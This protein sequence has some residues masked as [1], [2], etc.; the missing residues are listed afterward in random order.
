MF[1]VSFSNAWSAATQSAK[2]AVSKIVDES[3]EKIDNIASEIK[4]KAIEIGKKA[5]QKVEEGVQYTKEKANDAKEYTKE[6]AIEAKEYVKQKA[7]ETKEVA[8]K[9]AKQAKK[10]FDKAADLFP[11][12]ASF[13][14]AP[15]PLTALILLNKLTDKN[16]NADWDGKYLPDCKVCPDGSTCIATKGSSEP[17]NKGKMPVSGCCRNPIP[18]VYFVNG[19]MNDPKKNCETAKELAIATCSEV[20]SVYNRTEGIVKDVGECLGNI[21]QVYQ[22]GDNAPTDTMSKLMEDAIMK[23]PPKE[24]TICAHSQGGLITRSSL[25]RVKTKLSLKYPP[26][27]VKERMSKINIKSFGTAEDN[28]PEGPNYEQ[29]TNPNDLVPKAIAKTDAVRDSMLKP[30]LMY[31]NMI[32]PDYERQM[33][34]YN[35]NKAQMAVITNKHEVNERPGL[36]NKMTL[37]SHGMSESY[38]PYLKKTPKIDSKT[39]KEIKCANCPK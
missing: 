1:G 35:A 37:T 32:N 12:L 4:N 14:I 19:I 3:I 8:K 15:C 22:P 39:G 33:A 30:K 7:K 6:K 17:P 21:F 9:I 27:E 38:I 29:Y 34:Q 13:A 28:W 24:V 25:D 10:T 2:E 23:D 16:V 31:G 26:E 18:T 36:Y 20:I 5:K 11:A